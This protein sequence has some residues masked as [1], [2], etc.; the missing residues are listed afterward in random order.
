MASLRRAEDINRQIDIMAQGPPETAVLVP[1]ECQDFLTFIRNSLDII[2]ANEHL[3]A[4]LELVLPAARRRGR[5]EAERVEAIM[6]E[7]E[8]DIRREEDGIVREATRL[9]ECIAR[10]RR[11]RIQ[12]KLDQ[13]PS[14]LCSTCLSEA[15]DASAIACILLDRK[16]GYIISRSLKTTREVMAVIKTS[17]ETLEG[18]NA[19]Y[20]T[21]VKPVF[22]SRADLDVLRLDPRHLGF[23]IHEDPSRIHLVADNFYHPLQAASTTR[24]EFRHALDAAG[25]CDG[26]SQ[27][28][29]EMRARMFESGTWPVT[30]E[31]ERRMIGPSIAIS[32]LLRGEKA[33]AI[34]AAIDAII[35]KA[36]RLNAELDTIIDREIEQDDLRY[37]MKLQEAI[38]ELKAAEVH[39]AM[40][41]PDLAVRIREL[42]KRLQKAI[43]GRSASER[44]AAAETIVEG[45]K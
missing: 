13:G 15:P 35:S 42:K 21:R 38:G 33:E 5:R 8:R 43:W 10:V 24:H 4:R 16:D 19:T 41:Y 40:L 1:A 26:C 37:K 12:R 27:E 22:I 31:E 3:L 39:I 6:E 11:G 20:G 30:P 2:R 14:L 18:L 7:T 28:E 36:E 34:N 23:V 17:M 45:F 25:A 32:S 9:A 44:A 29:R